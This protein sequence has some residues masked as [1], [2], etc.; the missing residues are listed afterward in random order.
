MAEEQQKAVAVNPLVKLNGGA[1]ALMPTNLEEAYRVSQ[2]LANSGLVPSSM[3]GNA[4]AVF[5]GILLSTELGVPP[6]SGLSNISVVNGRASVWGELATAIVR[7]SGL[8]E[9][10]APPKFTGTGASMKVSVTGKRKG[11]KDEVTFE[12]S[13]DDA[14]LAG[15]LEKDTYKK[16]PKDMIMWK[17]LHRLFKFLW[18]DVLKGLTFKE[19]AGEVIE[20]EVEGKVEIGGAAEALPAEIP[21]PAPEKDKPAE[22]KPEPDPELSAEEL[23]AKADAAR[24]KVKAQEEAE[25]KAKAEPAAKTEPEDAE[26]VTENPKDAGAKLPDGDIRHIG[27]VT[28]C[29]Y[30]ANA[31]KSGYDYFVVLSTASGEIRLQ[32]AAKSDAEA[33][34]KLKGKTVTVVA[35]NKGEVVRY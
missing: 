17:A 3:R 27:T 14:R 34:N 20:A 29:P 21:A 35:N 4:D 7:S 18:P 26:L 8:C 28:R 1:V 32:C 33:F 16:N 9:Y 10:L 2:R 30:K 11:E 15:H 22:P 19:F 13:M 6:M 31:D 25:A 24:A 5:A 23:K 12:Y